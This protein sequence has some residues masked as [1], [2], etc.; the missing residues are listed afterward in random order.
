VPPPPPPPVPPP[1]P[2]PP[3]PPANITRTAQW[4]L[5]SADTTLA[6]NLNWQTCCTLTHAYGANE[7]WL[8]V[9]AFGWGSLAGSTA[10]DAATSRLVRNLGSDVEVGHAGRPRWP[11]NVD[12][13]AIVSAQTYG[14]TAGS[15]SWRVDAQH[16]AVGFTATIQ[17]PLIVGI[18]LEANEGYA[19]DFG[20]HGDSA[21]TFVNACSY[22]TG[23]LPA[24][25][26]VIVAGMETTAS[27]NILYDC[28]L[29]ID[30][31]AAF[32]AVTQSRDAPQAGSFVTFWPVTL[33]NAAHTVALQ[34]RLTPG[35]TGTAT[36]SNATVAV[37][38]AAAFQKAQWDASGSTGSYTSTG[39]TA[40]LSDSWTLQPSPY[41]TLLLA[42]GQATVP[43][44]AAA[45]AAQTR[46]RRNAALLAPAASQ[47][48]RV[49]GSGAPNSVAFAAIVQPANTTDAF[50][51]G[52]ASS[53]GSSLVTL[54]GASLIALALA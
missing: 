2:P 30:G 23:T 7:K 42:S 50:D 32:P 33:T 29:L 24:G 36:A 44:A 47:G 19:Q 43:Q 17:A 1:P 41:R 13:C 14:G 16:Q 35:Q 51:L 48:A 28:R 11:A 18:R 53:D 12:R 37:L 22:T 49:D 34:V 21:G 26:Y 31:A 3:P 6:N 9:A 40:K 15:A 38:S 54:Q 10:S 52:E 8:Y 45:T 20:P 27:G 5:A 39:Y 25:D 4:A 46:L